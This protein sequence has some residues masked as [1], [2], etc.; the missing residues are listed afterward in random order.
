MTEIELEQYFNTTK[1]DLIYGILKAVGG[2]MNDIEQLFLNVDNDILYAVLKKLREGG[3]GGQNFAN[4]DLT[5]TGDR[6]HDLNNFSL[7]IKGC[8]LDGDGYSSTLTFSRFYHILLNSASKIDINSGDE[9]DI[10]SQILN[11]GGV[12]NWYLKQG[13]LNILYGQFNTESDELI[14]DP[15]F[16]LFQ[17]WTNSFE[18]RIITQYHSE[19]I[20]IRDIEFNIKTR[21]KYPRLGELGN[22]KNYTEIDGVYCATIATEE[23]VNSNSNNKIVLAA[24]IDHYTV[25]EGKILKAIWFQ[26]GSAA[27]IGVGMSEG[28]NDLF[29]PGEL[30]A[31]GDLV[32]EGLKPFRESGEIFFNGVQEDTV[33]IIY[34]L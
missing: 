6:T 16:Q 26:G 31:G 24:G 3:L 1:Q 12:I 11:F 5:F 23:Y 32:F 13:V 9:I 29:D 4:S 15:Y 34:L 2:G 22:N 20:D 19:F 8:D 7:W 27:N 18:D 30:T 21:L 33:T 10:K 17:K 28:T 25:I 14:Q